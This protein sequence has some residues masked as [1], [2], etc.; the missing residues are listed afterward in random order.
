MCNQTEP[1]YLLALLM[2]PKMGN[3]VTRKCL[4]LQIHGTQKDSFVAGDQGLLFGVPL[5]L[6]S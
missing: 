5:L 3:R 6:I 4:F 2:Y 1:Q